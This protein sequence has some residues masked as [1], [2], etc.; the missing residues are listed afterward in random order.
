MWNVL[1]GFPVRRLKKEAECLCGV[2]KLGNPS[3]RDGGRRKGA[4]FLTE[5][6]YK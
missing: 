1:S 2:E 6:V 5:E 4:A 3:P